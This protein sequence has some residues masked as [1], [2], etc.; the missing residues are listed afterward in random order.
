MQQI[1]INSK[2]RNNYEKTLSTDFIFNLPHEIKNVKSYA[3]RYINTA[4]LNVKIYL[5]YIIVI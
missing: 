3:F 2:F 4:F 1:N 5:N